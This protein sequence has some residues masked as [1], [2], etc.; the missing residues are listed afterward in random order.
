MARTGWGL[1]SV[2]GGALRRVDGGVIATSPERPQVER[3]R[4]VALAMTEVAAA[5]RPDVACVERVFANRNGKTT[6]A[7]GEARGAAL[8]ALALAGVATVEMSALQVKRAVTGM[9]RADKHQVAE[10]VARLLDWPE[11]RTAGRD[12]TDALACAIAASSPL[13][14]SSS[15]LPPNTRRRGGGKRS[16]GIRIRV[17]TGMGKLTGTVGGLGRVGG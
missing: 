2:R 8:A 5:H 7:L 4:A 15:R 6:L 14:R 10:M 12:E 11:A 1:L 13:A 17:R 3:L 16:G 9:G